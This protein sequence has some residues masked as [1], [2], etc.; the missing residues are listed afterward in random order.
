MI[1]RL[2]FGVVLGVLAVSG[3]P[4]IGDDPSLAPAPPGVRP[5]NVLSEFPTE[6]EAYEGATAA[7]VR[8]RVPERYGLEEWEAVV[9]THEFHQHIGIYTVL[10]AKM[11]V[12]AR[13]VL[14]AP[15]RAVAVTAETGSGQPLSCMLDGLQVGLGSTLGQNLIRVPEKEKGEVAAQFTYKERTIRLSLKP[16]YQERIG[17]LIQ[18]ARAHYGD[19]TPAY[20]HAVA[21]A[22]YGVWADFDRKEIFEVEEKSGRAKP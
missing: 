13:E 5:L 1:M 20:F 16:E 14:D 11:A 22:S 2:R 15:M 9:L 8:E 4:A 17:Q 21:H 10:G 6:P 18:V 3:I 19:L 12:R 7:L